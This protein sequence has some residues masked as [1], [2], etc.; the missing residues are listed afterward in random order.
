MRLHPDSSR[1]SRLSKASR[2]K[3]RLTKASRTGTS[4]T[5]T[6]R[7][8]TAGVAVQASLTS[9]TGAVLIRREEAAMATL[10]EAPAVAVV[11]Q[12]R[13]GGGSALKWKIGEE[14]NVF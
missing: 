10:E 12:A 14:K 11:H 8:S 2:R 3:S 13:T 9:T 4:R 7:T 5:G 6:A 1:N